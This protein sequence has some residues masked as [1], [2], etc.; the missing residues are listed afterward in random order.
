MN[1]QL[2]VPSWARAS[3]A[4]LLITLAAAGMARASD[5]T[6]NPNS[7]NSP[8]PAADARPDSAAGA[9][10]A[11]ADTT[12]PHG[13]PAELTVV[14]MPAVL[15]L[16]TLKAAIFVDARSPERYADGHIPG[17]LSCNADDFDSSY[18]KVQARLPK[19]A[20]IVLYCDGVDCPMAHDLGYRLLPLGYTNLLY[21]KNGWDE[22]DAAKA[23]REPAAA[24]PTH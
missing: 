24:T 17:A 23:P 10:A 15:R 4:G 11:Q 12:L 13:K 2:F 20:R 5:P 3:A 19:G 7:G 8:A 14:E 1:R 9:S 16:L 6:G 22:W 21:Y 18:A